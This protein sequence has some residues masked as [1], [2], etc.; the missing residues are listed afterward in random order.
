M[1]S[2]EPFKLIIES[3]KFIQL[4]SLIIVG[5]FVL[6]IV[7]NTIRFFIF[8]FPLLIDNG[9]FLD[10]SFKD[11]DSQ[12]IKRFWKIWVY[13]FGSIVGVFIFLYISDLLN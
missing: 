4:S 9:F 5:L 13:I 12:V 10:K 1:S 6:S 8:F 7:I 2:I 3:G 11:L